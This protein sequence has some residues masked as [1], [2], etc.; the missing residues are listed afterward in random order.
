MAARRHADTD[1]DG[2]SFACLSVAQQ[3]RLPCGQWSSR[4][5]SPPFVAA[6]LVGACDSTPADAEQTLKALS[7]T[8][9]IAVPPPGATEI[10]FAQDPE[11]ISSITGHDPVM[12]KIFATLQSIGDV[13]SYYE[14]TYPQYRLTQ[15]GAPVPQKQLAGQDGWAYVTI[16]ISPGEPNLA[17]ANLPVKLSPAPPTATTSVVVIVSGQEPIATTASPS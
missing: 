13:V 16:N 3:R 10:G 6:A 15:N 14:R 7:A 1:D 12:E 8:R 2:M 11:S 4:P 5:S 17:V 9:V